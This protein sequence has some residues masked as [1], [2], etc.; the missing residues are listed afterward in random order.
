MIH[1]KILILGSNGFI[2][3]NLK[4]NLKNSDEDTNYEFIYLTKEK[5]DLKNKM[6]LKNYMEWKKPNIVINASGV[7]G[8]SLLNKEK[9][10]YIIFNENIL[11]L[12]NILDCCQETKVEKLILFSTYRLFGDDVRENYHE[13]DIHNTIIKNNVGYLESKRIQNTQMEL[14]LKYYKMKIVC[15]IM[16]NVFGEEDQFINNGK[17]VPS[18]IT[19]IKNAKRKD[20]NLYIDAFSK[21]KVNLIYVKDI[22]NMVKHCIQQEDECLVGNILI[23]N[24]KGILE[25]GELAKKLSKIIDYKGTIEFK[26]DSNFNLKQ[27][28]DNI[29]KPD[30]SKMECFFPNFE[31]TDINEALQMIITNLSF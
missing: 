15:F 14:F 27:E 31:F 10:E 1:K 9:N 21:N 5:I 30:L 23:F 26:D 20:E 19:K 29:M 13:D 12:M 18:F 11:I 16:P 28:E 8:S 3:K 24:K 6:A 22:V 17:I 4:N 7:I 2:G 25:I